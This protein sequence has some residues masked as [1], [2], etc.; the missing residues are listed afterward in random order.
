MLLRISEERHGETTLVRVEG[1][2]QGD[3]VAELERTCR[4]VTGPVMLDLSALLTA[5]EVGLSLL[6]SLRDAGAVVT[7]ASPFL[8]LLLNGSRSET[9]RRGDA[10]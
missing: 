8:R 4:N 9:R 3:G 10:A 2:L 5:D 1:H 7:G 6:R